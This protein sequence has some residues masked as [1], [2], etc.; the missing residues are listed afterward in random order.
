MQRKGPP[1][2][3]ELFNM[4]YYAL[5]LVTETNPVNVVIEEVPQYLGVKVKKHGGG[6]ATLYDGPWK[7]LRATLKAAG[8]HVTHKVVDSADWG[9]AASRPRVY[10]V[11]TTK[12]GFSWDKAKK[13]GKAP[14]GMRGKAKDILLPPNHP[15]ILSARNTQGN[16]F[17]TR[18][19]SGMGNTMRNAWARKDEKGKPKFQPT[20]IDPN[21]PIQTVVKR[22]YAGQPTGPFV[23]HPSKP[24]TYRLLTTY[25]IQKLHGVPEDYIL[26]QAP[27][28][29]VE[30]IG[31]AVI[32]PLVEGIVRA[33]PGGAPSRTVDASFRRTRNPAPV[34]PMYY[35]AGPLFSTLPWWIA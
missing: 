19:R 28:P 35:G 12:G 8:Y 29:R 27:T 24:D 14:R 17:S 6:T 25:E 30:V 10:I 15:A 4:T 3:H 34:V 33:L 26:P 20:F 11:A 9:Y 7:M 16:W 31:Q 13:L 22:Y 23:K 18:D 32:V 2:E 5:A 21:K 1:D